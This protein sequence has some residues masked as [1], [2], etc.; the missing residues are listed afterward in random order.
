MKYAATSDFKVIGQ[1]EIVIICVPT[2]IDKDQ[3]PNLSFL[4]KAIL[5]IS[6]NLREGTLVINESTVAPGTTR[7]LIRVN[8]EL[9]KVNFELAYSPERIDPG[10]K[11]WNV[12]NTPKLV[13]GITNSATIRAAEF[14]RSF[15]DE[16]LTGTSPEVVELA[17]LL[18]N[19]FR[20][21]NISFI[22]EFAQF[23]DA[24]NVDPRE[25]IEAASSKPYGFMAFYPSAGVGGH[26]IPVDPFYLLAKAREIGVSTR[27]IEAA[28]EINLSIPVYFTTRAEQILGNLSGKKI[29]LVGVGYKSNLSDVRETPALGL[30]KS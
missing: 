22:N 21:I 29:M 24:M 20:L 12:R 3:K 15:V 14:Y 4:E 1:S 23:C 18:E 26:C 25:V 13:S 17:K 10:N 6:E 16:V 27:S 7:D 19:S 8:L 28:N 9:S 5:L 11:I 30:K 2:P